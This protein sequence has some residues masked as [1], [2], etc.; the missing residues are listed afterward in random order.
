MLCTRSA[1]AITTAMKPLH[2]SNGVQSY[3]LIG[4]HRKVDLGP[5]YWGYGMESGV[6]SRKSMSMAVQKTHV[7]TARTLQY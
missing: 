4:P 1:L 2:G 3:F 5:G 6:H 7:G